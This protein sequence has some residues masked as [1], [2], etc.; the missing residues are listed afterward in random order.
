[1][2]RA[3][4]EPLLARSFDPTAMKLYENTKMISMVEM[5]SSSNTGSYYHPDLMGNSDSTLG[6]SENYS[7]SSRT[8]ASGLPQ[9][10]TMLIANIAPLNP[11]AKMMAAASRVQQGD[12]VVKFS[13]SYFQHMKS[14]TVAANLPGILPK[15]NEVVHPYGP[16]LDFSRQHHSGK[17]NEGEGGGSHE[18]TSTTHKHYLFHRVSQ[19]MRGFDLVFSKNLKLSDNDRKNHLIFYALALL[20]LTTNIVAIFTSVEASDAQSC[21]IIIPSGT[22]DCCRC[23]CD[24]KNSW[25]VT[26]P[27]MYGNVS[28]PNG[29]SDLIPLNVFGNYYSGANSVESTAE[30]RKLGAAAVY[31]LSLLFTLV[32]LSV[33]RVRGNWYMLLCACLVLVLQAARNLYLHLPVHDWNNF[34]IVLRPLDVIVLS[35]DGI[36]LLSALLATTRLRSLRPVFYTTQFHHFGQLT[37]HQTTL[38]YYN[39]MFAT[40]LLDWQTSSLLHFQLAILASNN[41]QMLACMGVLYVCDV[42]SSYVG[43]TYIRYERYW[44]TVVAL[45][46]KVMLTLSWIAIATYVVWCYDIFR[47]RAL[48]LRATLLSSQFLGVDAADAQAYLLGHCG[49]APVVSGSGDMIVM[50]AIMTTAF[51]VRVIS[52]FY[53]ALLLADFGKEIINSLFFDVVAIQQRRGLHVDDAQDTLDVRKVRR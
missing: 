16:S 41:V 51:F 13:N 1:M 31:V 3:A 29:G 8:C 2:N 36:S 27:N 19:I 37:T 44:D 32:Q 49:I 38:R 50:F 15:A 47:A 42:L 33:A 52:I 53:A 28:G 9:T 43:Y 45:V 5:P 17:E 14:V 46:S 6:L 20:S 39:I 30:A 11:A 35:A 4:A 18:F 26:I 21:N 7:S 22:D 25:C 12:T 23:V 40:S 48:F 34:A 24:V 10:Q